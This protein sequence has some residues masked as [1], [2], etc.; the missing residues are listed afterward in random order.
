MSSNPLGINH[1][2][3]NKCILQG[4]LILMLM[5]IE[6]KVKPWHLYM[7]KCERILNRNHF[8][9]YINHNTNTCYP[10]IQSTPRIFLSSV[11]THHFLST[12]MLSNRPNEYCGSF[13]YF[14]NIL[15]V[16]WISISE[17][18][19]KQW[20]HS[21]N[22]HQIKRKCYKIIKVAIIPSTDIY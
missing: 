5:N 9:F 18:I 20:S 7:K 21:V 1:K 10:Y 6:W 12:H 19:K 17:E 13:K 16:S 3:W 2:R 22:C 11:Y 8:Y 14:K 15:W 4:I